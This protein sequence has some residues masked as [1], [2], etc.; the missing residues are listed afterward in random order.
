MTT[1]IS[2]SSAHRVLSSIFGVSSKVT[3][4]ILIR[5][6]LC[7]FNRVCQFSKS[8]LNASVLFSILVIS[9]SLQAQSFEDL[10]ELLLTHPQL[11]SMK[12]QA[13]SHKERSDAA[14]GLPD[15]VVS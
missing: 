8:L 9:P 14:M 6:C 11:Q 12:Y 10:D 4:H 5:C 1:P 13:E 3:S 2:L 15:P 7:R